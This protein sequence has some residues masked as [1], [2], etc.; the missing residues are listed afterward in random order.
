V[1]NIENMK[2]TTVKVKKTVEKRDKMEN[3][4]GDN[5]GP[6]TLPKPRGSMHQRLGW[7]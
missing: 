6:R 1:E 7:L 2:K 5:Y 3:E 4:R